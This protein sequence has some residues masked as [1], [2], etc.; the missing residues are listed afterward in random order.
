MNG[1]QIF[2]Y[3]IKIRCFPESTN[4][5]DTSDLSRSPLMISTI[6]FESSRMNKSNKE[7]KPIRV[8]VSIN[9]KDALAFSSV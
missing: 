8:W 5:I 9:E 4:R 3:S 6:F 7:Q 2:T 1:Q